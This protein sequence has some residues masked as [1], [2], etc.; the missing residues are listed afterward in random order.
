MCVFSVKMVEVGELG[1][2]VIGVAV[3]VVGVWRTSSGNGSKCS[4]GSSEL[5]VSSTALNTA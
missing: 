5:F 1:I 2:E 3:P 4:S